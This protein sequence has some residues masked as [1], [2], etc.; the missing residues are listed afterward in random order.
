MVLLENHLTQPCSEISNSQF[1]KDHKD[2]IIWSK[3]IDYLP[4]RNYFL[5]IL[6]NIE[7][8]KNENL[9]DNLKSTFSKIWGPSTRPNAQ[10]KITNEVES[11]LKLLNEYK[12]IKKLDSFKYYKSCNQNFENFLFLSSYRIEESA[13]TLSIKRSIFLQLSE[14][15]RLEA[16]RNILLELIYLHNIYGMYY[17]N[18]NMDKILF[19]PNPNFNVH[20]FDFKDLIE[21]D[22]YQ[23]SDVDRHNET[24]PSSS[25]TVNFYNALERENFNDIDNFFDI[26]IDL[27]RPPK[28]NDSEIDSWKTKE[29]I[30]NIKE[31]VYYYLFRK[32]TC[33]PNKYK[34]WHKYVKGKELKTVR[35][36][37]YTLIT[38]MN[39]LIEKLQK[40]LLI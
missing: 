13:E 33:G 38:K 2:H 5:Y 25:C 34:S 12:K 30:N 27:E 37:P 9:E 20:L 8:K 10:T 22:F 19:K 15:E 32:V 24:F 28:L 21:F 26:I 17:Q 7:F 39:E 35:P 40:R 31:L 23:E 3:K 29:E 18:F 6:E 11:T 1:K 16:Y 36:S 14:V 4:S